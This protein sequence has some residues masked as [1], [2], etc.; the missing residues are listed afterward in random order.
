MAR[1]RLDNLFIDYNIKDVTDLNIKLIQ[2]IRRDSRFTKA[3]LLA[4]GAKL[5]LDMSA[6]VTKSDIFNCIETSIRKQAS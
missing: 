4:L 6:V 2:K 3:L 5:N 1:C